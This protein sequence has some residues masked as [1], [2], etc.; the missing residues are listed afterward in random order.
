MRVT[1]L[2]MIKYQVYFTDK[3]NKQVL[4][5]FIYATNVD[6]AFDKAALYGKDYPEFI[7]HTVEPFKE[8]SYK[9]SVN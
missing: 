2:F 9:M 4:T 5:C 8:V 7:I 6:E 3:E 1:A